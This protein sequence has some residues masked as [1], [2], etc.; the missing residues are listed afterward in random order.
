MLNIT[1]EHAFRMQQGSRIHT[2]AF[3]ISPIVG[4][5]IVVG[6]IPG[7]SLIGCKS[8]K[9]AQGIA[10]HVV[11]DAI[12]AATNK[13]RMS[14]EKCQTSISIQTITSTTEVNN[15][16]Q[17]DADHVM[18]GEVSVP[19][20]DFGTIKIGVTEFEIPGDQMDATPD[21]ILLAKATDHLQTLTTSISLECEMLQ[22]H[23]DDKDL[24][25]RKIAVNTTLPQS[26]LE[27]I[28]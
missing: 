20:D 18:T 10:A 8:I 23:L 9:I 21:S 22:R 7:I 24:D 12:L 13:M 5:G 15:S 17:I 27:R 6:G 11:I 1:L 16:F 4:D 14:P 19:T 3:T 25:L 26:V 28:R 2:I